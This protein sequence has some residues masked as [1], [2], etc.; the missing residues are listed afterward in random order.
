MHPIHGTYIDGSIVPDNR[1]DWPNGKRVVIE[2]VAQQ[3]IEMMT[4]DDQGSDPESI[5][6]WLAL[7]DA[8]PQSSSSPLDDPAVNAWRETMRN[9][10]MEAV[11]RQLEEMEE[12]S[13]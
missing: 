12:A 2:P 7:V 3:S 13:E 6:K 8:I 10:N 1:P 4:E 11:R 5:A 9:F